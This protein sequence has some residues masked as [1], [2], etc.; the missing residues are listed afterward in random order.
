M[1]KKV[2]KY[3]TGQVIPEG[4]VYLSTQVEDT[5]YVDVHMTTGDQ[6]RTR[7]NVLV[8]HYFLADTLANA[9]AEMWIYLKENDLLSPN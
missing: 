2:Y 1:T 8:W 6:I 9:A 3:G 7:K 5:V 4:A